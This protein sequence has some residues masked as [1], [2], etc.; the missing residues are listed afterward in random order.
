MGTRMMG[1][2]RVERGEAELVG[3]AERTEGGRYWLSNLDQ[4]VAVVVRTVY[5]YGGGAAA[6]GA[7]VKRGLAAAL[8][9]YYPAAG[10]V[11]EWGEEG[12]LAV[13]CTGEGAVFVEARADQHLRAVGD[14]SAGGDPAAL[15]PLV[16]DLPAA[17]GS[18]LLAAQVTHFRCG[19]FTV[20]LSMNHCMFDGIAAMEF[21]NCWSLAARGLPVSP[22]FLDRSLLAARSPPLLL[23]PHPEFSELPDLSAGAATLPLL[24]RTF[25]FSSEHLMK[26]KR[27]VAAEGGCGDGKLTA[28]C[29][30]FEAL[31]ALV[32]QARVAAL[33]LNPAQQ[34]KLLFAVD[35]RRRVVPP[36]PPRYFGNAIVLTYAMSTAGE[37]VSGS[38][39]QAVTMIQTAISRVNDSFV[40]SAI[41]FFELTRAK[42]SLVG[43]LLVTAWSKLAFHVA[44]FG[45]GPPQQVGPAALPEKEVVLFLP[46]GRERNKVNVLLGLPASAMAA[47]E[48]HLEP[49]MNT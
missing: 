13:E 36:L 10:R 3:P 14:V 9:W 6:A 37:L 35:V 16:Y 8:V 43:T 46:H 29:T 33:C 41:D 24:Y 38:L 39:S 31:S 44:D 5:C 2:V 22:P 40:R 42:P 21:L 30:S 25:S 15:L 47:F 49:Y 1:K 19:G 48:G 17:P 45:W 32:W 26:L 34:T 4:N 23:H 18:P 7:A 28:G 20:G 27:M 11:G 12:K